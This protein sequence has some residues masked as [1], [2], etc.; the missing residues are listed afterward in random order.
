MLKPIDYSTAP[1][2]A[3]L[4][5][6][7][8][9]MLK[10]TAVASLIISCGIGATANAAT[11]VDAKNLPTAKKAAPPISPDKKIYLNG[12]TLTP[13]G[14]IEGAG[15]FRSKNLQSDIITLYNTIPYNVSPLAHLDEFR[16]S[17]RQSRFSMLI[18]GKYNPK[19]NVTGFVEIDFLGAGRANSVQANVFEP[20]LRHAYSNLDLTDSGW[21]FLA[22][23]VWSLTDQNRKGILP[24]NVLNPIS[25]EN[26]SNVGYVLKRTPQFRVTKDFSKTVWAALSIENPQTTFATPLAAAG[27]LSAPI[28]GVI[29]VTNAAV[30]NGVLSPSTIFSL[31]HI[32]DVVG[33]LAFD[34]AFSAN[35]LHLEV[36]G[37]YRNY[38][39]RVQYTNNVNRTIDNNG[40]GFGG[41]IYWEALPKRLELQAN[42]MAGRG[43]GSYFSSL[44]PDTTIDADGG[45][46]PISEIG[47]MVGAVG[48]A[49]P[50][51][52]L[53][54]YGGQSKQDDSFFATNAAGTTFSGFG[55]PN[56]NN[57][58]C[59]IENSTLGCAGLTRE[60]WQVSAGLWQK[61][62]KGNAGQV[63]G[64]LQYSYI[65]KE[66][67][68]GNGTSVA[69]RNGA[70][71]APTADLHSAYVSV[72]YLPFTVP[73]PAVAAVVYK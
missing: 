68:A 59:D 64:G 55:V 63:V 43:I 51:L 70:F 26:T 40:G 6:S 14:F 12:I 29:S 42:V 44:L 54:I 20:R 66:A 33:K 62:Y 52:D 3:S 39:D 35:P 53:Y 9:K 69:G 73:T 5:N 11:Q 65:K 46:K 50:D 21:H 1:N 57:T 41:S 47:F 31:N 37:V 19:T 2:K 25:I 23:Q 18:E 8:G 60:I 4:S 28:P 15:I 72:R 48:H 67:F 36:F 22:G 56:A 32:P 49:T 58:G 17:A 34:P 24:L 45:L 38:Y 30:G 71:F 10:M 16:L 7:R 61:L 13:G 27:G